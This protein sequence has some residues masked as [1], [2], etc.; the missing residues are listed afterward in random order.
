MTVATRSLLGEKKVFLSFS[1]IEDIIGTFL[2]CTL[3]N[4]GSLSIFFGVVL[5]FFGVKRLMVRSYGQDWN[6]HMGVNG[7][8]DALAVS[9][10][11]LAQ[12]VHTQSERVTVISFGWKNNCRKGFWKLLKKSIF[13][14][15]RFAYLKDTATLNDVRS[16]ASPRFYCTFK[17]V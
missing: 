7:Q 13:H 2:R 8:C 14:L 9:Q 17:T 16:V 15:F 11:C 10:L 12:Y 6:E 5:E 4:I 3:L 1:L